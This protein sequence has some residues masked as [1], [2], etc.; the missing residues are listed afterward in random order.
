MSIRKL[1]NK[2]APV[3]NMSTDA[4]V[5][6]NQYKISSSS[7]NSSSRASSYCIT[8]FMVSIYSSTPPSW[9]FVSSHLYKSTIKSIILLCSKGKCQ[10]SSSTSVTRGR[11]LSSILSIFFRNFLSS[12]SSFAIFANCSS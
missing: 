2:K 7:S 10:V 3:L 11:I 5:R 1:K 12:F 4:F 6:K 9:K 8:S